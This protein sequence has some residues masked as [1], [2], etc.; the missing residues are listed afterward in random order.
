MKEI[1]Q[2]L[3]TKETLSEKEAYDTLV[4]I[5]EGQY[6][7][8]QVTAFMTVFMMRP[9]T[10]D[11]LYGFRAALLSLCVP[12]DLGTDQVI[13]LCGT[14]GDG[15][16]TFNI[17]TLASFVVA[18]AGY[19]VAK[20]GN[21]GVSS[22]SG[23]SNVLEMLGYQ[24]TNNVGELKNQL[25]RA[26]ICFMHAPLFHPAMK[27]VAPIRKALGMKTFFNLLGPLVN[28]AKPKYQ[29]TGVFSPEI[30]NLYQK[31]LVKAKKQFTVIHSID[32]YDEISLTAPVLI[33]TTNSNKIVYPQEFGMSALLPNELVGGNNVQE[34]A[35]IFMKILRGDGNAAQN[36]VVIANAGMAIQCMK[37]KQSLEHCMDAAKVSLLSKKAQKTLEKLL[38]H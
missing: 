21:Y 32:G 37:P 9:V 13:D 7:D 38:N 15:K 34:A 14:G 18:G 20:H 16:H 17:S 2:R 28:P 1:L 27:S 6:N 10:I 12:V 11:E 24:F 5:S 3:F 22:V 35:D 26:G 36:N 31:V 8:A 25:D 30:A 29:C 19:K 23:S 4:H 33:K